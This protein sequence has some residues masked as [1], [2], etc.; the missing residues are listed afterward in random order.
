MSNKTYIWCKWHKAWV[1]HNP[2]VTSGPT[3][4]KLRLA[5][6]GTQNTRQPTMSP[7]TQLVMTNK[8]T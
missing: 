4:C 5:E 8:F 1:I 3:A 2:Y 7:K 6:E